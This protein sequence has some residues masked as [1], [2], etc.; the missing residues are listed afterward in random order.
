MGVD[1]IRN[2]CID[3]FH[4]KAGSPSRTWWVGRYIYL[5]TV[6]NF[7]NN[8]NSQDSH[9]LHRYRAS[10]NNIMRWCNGKSQIRA[11]DEVILLQSRYFCPLIPGM[12]ISIRFLPIL[13]RRFQFTSPPDWGYLNM[14]SIPWPQCYISMSNKPILEQEFC[15]FVPAQV[16]VPFLGICLHTVVEVNFSTWLKW[17]KFCNSSLWLLCFIAFSSSSSSHWLND[18]ATTSSLFL[19]GVYPCSEANWPPNSIINVRQR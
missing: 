9:Y 14:W 1:L 3:D 16:N 5:V 13:R 8:L 7:G 6:V 2:W 19:P 18:P 11:R 10:R 17:N 15:D 12:A 4:V